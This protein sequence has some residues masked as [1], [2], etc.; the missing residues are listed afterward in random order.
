MSF[1]ERQKRSYRSNVD[2]RITKSHN[3][4]W[5]L[6]CRSKR[7]NAANS[8]GKKLNALKSD[9]NNCLYQLLFVLR[10]RPF[11]QGRKECFSHALSPLIQLQKYKQITSACYLYLYSLTFSNRTEWY[12]SKSLYFCRV[13][14]G[15]RIMGRLQPKGASEKLPMTPC[16][17][18]TPEKTYETPR[19]RQVW[20]KIKQY[21]SENV[22]SSW[23]TW[24][25]YAVGTQW[26]C[27]G[28]GR[29][30]ISCSSLYSGD[31]VWKQPKKFLFR[32]RNQL[33]SRKCCWWFIQRLQ[34]WS[35]KAGVITWCYGARIY[36]D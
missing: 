31:V 5:F 10:Q 24:L 35:M 9:T 32:E 6:R 23:F 15:A 20:S 30:Q 2:S 3:G 34:N 14:S 12:N 26:C 11:A 18:T 4:S 27:V 25:F 13:S 21:C 29:R 36:T 17:A 22:K 28:R 1:F 33:K 8:I 7:C 16:A 19:T